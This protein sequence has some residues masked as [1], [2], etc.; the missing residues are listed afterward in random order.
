[1]Q[2]LI[3]KTHV[4]A[5]CN[6]EAKRLG[7][8]QIKMNPMYSAGWPD[9]EYF[10]PG[11]KPLLIEYKVPGK[12]LSPLQTVRVEYLR[13]NGYNVHVVDTKEEGIALIREAVDSYRLHEA[14]NEVADGA[15]RG[16]ASSRPRTKKD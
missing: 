3:E 10:V 13:S 2:V 16:R 14:V 11:G 7:V 1:M 15:P 12:S 9:R 6:R 4:E 5:P 8:E